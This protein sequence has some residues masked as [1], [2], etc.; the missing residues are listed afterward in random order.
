MA[1]TVLSAFFRK[2]P[3][4]FRNVAAFL[5]DDWSNVHTVAELSGFAADNVA[6][7]DS[8]RQIVPNRVHEAIGLEGDTWIDNVMGPDSRL[9]RAER[10]VCAD[11]HSMMDYREELFKQR[12]GTDQVEARLRTIAGESTLNFLS[13]KAVIPKYVS[14]WT[15]WSSTHVP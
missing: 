1:A 5:E 9:A 10:E 11:Y 14:R 4:R 13:R 12:R 2:H 3:T 15:S 7:R 6:L 8:L